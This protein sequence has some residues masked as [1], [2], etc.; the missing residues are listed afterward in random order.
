MKEF[1]LAAPKKPTR[2]Q[3]N[4]GVDWSSHGRETLKRNVS[5]RPVRSRLVCSYRGTNKLLVTGRLG[6]I[7]QS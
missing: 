5:T 7:G 3:R 6:P 1:L 2:E 4:S